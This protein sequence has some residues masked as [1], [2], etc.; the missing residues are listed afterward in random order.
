MGYLFSDDITWCSESECPM[1]NCRRN[2]VNMINRV[3]LHS[4]ANF[5]GTS[6]CPVS[7]SL[8][9]C[10]D[11]CLYAKQCFSKHEDPDDAL[12][13]LVNEYCADC[14]FSSVEED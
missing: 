1:Q 2:V 3:G 9:E 6:E 7:V 13:E 5:K 14:A 11:G 12:D 10:M 8:D 4:F